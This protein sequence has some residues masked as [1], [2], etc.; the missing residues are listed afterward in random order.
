MM[1]ADEMSEERLRRIIATAGVR[2]TQRMDIIDFEAVLD[3]L[4]ED[5]N[6][7]YDDDDDKEGDEDEDDGSGVIR[8]VQRREVEEIETEVEVETPPKAHRGRERGMDS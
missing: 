1:T 2:D 3:E 6:G 7:D 5:I 8:E 4:T